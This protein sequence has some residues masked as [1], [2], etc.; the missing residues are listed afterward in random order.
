MNAEP[1]QVLWKGM[2]TAQVETTGKAQGD[3]TFRTSGRML[4][5]RLGSLEVLN[6]GV[7]ATEEEEEGAG[8]ILKARRLTW[9][10]QV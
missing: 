4:L 3:V 6:R 5:G 8:G 10:R 9:H 2:G 7:T 1:S